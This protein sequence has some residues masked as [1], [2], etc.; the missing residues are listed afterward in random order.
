MVEVVELTPEGRMVRLLCE[1]CVDGKLVLDG[2]AIV[3]VP[4]RACRAGL[5]SHAGY[6]V[7]GRGPVRNVQLPI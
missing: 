5:R 4:A 6:A 3:S 1:A 2:E 7:A